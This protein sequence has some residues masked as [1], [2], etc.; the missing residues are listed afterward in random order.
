LSTEMH[1][2]E[3]QRAATEQ[4]GAQSAR[5]QQYGGTTHLAEP[6]MA[7]EELSD[8]IERLIQRVQEK[9]REVSALPSLTSPSATRFDIAERPAP[10]RSPS[11]TSATTE[12]IA[13]LSES[14]AEPAEAPVAAESPVAAEPPVVQ[15][16]VYE[17]VYSPRPRAVTVE[18]SLSERWAKL[19][20]RRPSIDCRGATSVAEV[21]R[22]IEMVRARRAE[23]LALEAE[24]AAAEQTAEL[25]E[26]D[27]EPAEPPVAAELPVAAEP[28]MVQEAVAAELP[29]AAEPPVVQ[30]AV[31]EKVYSP[32]Q[33]AVTV[34]PSL[35]E[36]RAKLAA[37]RLSGDCGGATSVAEVRRKIEMVRARRAAQ[38]ALEAEQAAAEQAAEQAAAEQAAAEPVVPVSPL[39]SPS[40]SL[41]EFQ[42]IAMPVRDIER[43]KR[44][45]YYHAAQE[46][47][48]FRR[49]SEP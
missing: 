22:K 27:A 10:R 12:D 42:E 46:N 9:R 34:G 15:E 41:A 44:I 7:P 11:S 35:S 14:D 28:R 13:Q 48:D 30:E 24:Q 43:E 32:R 38:L 36:R 31:N 2:F 4:S 40:I 3:R 47:E 39:A 26:S 5:L 17:Q 19:A 33:R 16:A 18:P 29:V 21:R 23:R 49:L 20:A 6:E 1:G 8:V 37:R 25:S 45:Y